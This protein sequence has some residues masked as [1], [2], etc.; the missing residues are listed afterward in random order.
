MRRP[1]A[2]IARALTAAVF[3]AGAVIANAPARA[4][5]GPGVASPNM[6]Y[7]GRIPYGGGSD[8]EFQTR[9]DGRS[10]VYA[11]STRDFTGGPPAGLRI[12][13]ITDLGHP[14]LRGFLACDTNQNDIQVM[15]RG[16]KTYV[17]L[18]SDYSPRTSDCFTQLGI[19]A[20]SSGNA[21][22]LIVVDVT[23]AAEPRAVSL[24]RLGFGV[25]NETLHPAGRY[26]YISDSELTPPGLISS[27]TYRPGRLQV[28]D[29]ADP[30]RPQFVAEID[31]PEGRSAHDVTFSAD[32]SRAY[33]AALT[34]TVILDSSDPALPRVVSTILDPAINI[35]HQA[36]P[37]TAGR[38]KYLVITDELAGAAGNGFC[39]GGG[40]H[41]YD[42]SNELVPVKVAVFFVPEISQRYRCTSHV[43]RIDQAQRL[44][45]IAWYESGTWVIDISDPMR[46]RVVGTAN[47]SE[48]G[49][50]ADTW[51]AKMFR[52]FVFTNDL[53]RGM[54]IYH[55]TGPASREAVQKTVARMRSS[56]A[57]PPASELGGD[58]APKPYFC[59]LR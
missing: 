39:P 29:L 5:G 48:S 12:V 21:L 23:V 51:S 20:P 58:G 37:F 15:E 33:A 10:F 11:G 14:V 19:K 32:G 59:F 38:S 4:S 8:L 42:I 28:V 30:L 49:A 50:A 2:P 18:G 26:A 27:G 9:A 35:H 41:V 1:H 31:L 36:D 17:L 24:L 47:P 3:V 54:D 22:G 55:Y 57:P 56:L 40:L 25:H 53:R 45:T 13:E 7:V 44:M 16:P 43:L 34:Q 52:G 6:L 46:F